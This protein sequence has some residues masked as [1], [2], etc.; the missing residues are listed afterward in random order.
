MQRIRLGVAADDF[1]LGPK[2]GLEHAAHLGYAAVE[3]DATRGEADPANLSASGARHLRRLVEG[4][5]LDLATLGGYLGA[6]GL[7]DSASVQQRVDRTRHILELAARLR[8]PV[9]T[10]Y[11]G[12]VPDDP[13]DR[14]RQS[15]VGAVEHLGEHA[16]RTGTFLAV[17]TAQDSPATLRALLDEI[18]CPMVRTCYDPGRLL[19]HGHDPVAAVDELG[20]YI[21]ATHL[22][23]ATPGTPMAAGREVRIGTGQIN[24]LEVLVALEA[25]QYAGP[26]IVRRA[27]A[28]DPMADIAAARD[29]LEG[30]LR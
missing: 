5:G 16:D 1:G 21:I 30:L 8:V 6:S 19:M 14:R 11:L 24:F 26:Q 13:S 7:T 10:T 25:G 15:V 23:D 22:R 29:Y 9:V 4:L 27:D 18:D 3:L 17:Q 2:Q 20:D 28:A 12:S